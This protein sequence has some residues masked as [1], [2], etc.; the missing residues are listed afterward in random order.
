MQC[1]FVAH[2]FL[3]LRVYYYICFECKFSVTFTGVPMTLY[4]SMALGL[5]YSSQ[6]HLVN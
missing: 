1:R 5:Y 6:Q 3:F 4:L 2:M